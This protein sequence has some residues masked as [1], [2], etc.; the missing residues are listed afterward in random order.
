MQAAT[1]H[2]RIVTHPAALEQ[3]MA[4][5]MQL[6]RAR[7][8]DIVCIVVGYALTW[9]WALDEVTNGIPSWHTSVAGR[10]ETFTAAG[11]WIAVIS[12][13]IFTYSW[14]RWVWKVGV[15]TRFLYHVS[16]LR[17]RLYPAHPDRMGGLG[18]LSDVQT[19]FALLLFG[20]G[21]LFSAATWYKVMIEGTDVS[22]YTVWV[23][24]V[25]Y[26]ILAPGVFLAPLFLFT[27]KLHH[28]KTEGLLRFSAAGAMITRRFERRWMQARRSGEDIL[29]TTGHSAM[30]D[31]RTNFETVQKMRVVPFDARSVLEL[32]G[33]AAGPFVPLAKVFELPEKVRAFF[34]LIS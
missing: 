27:R 19:S 21:I 15:W 5:A 9:G 31:F 18:C 16:R 2:L 25:G 7:A 17:L 34:E 29:Q 24:I 28:V 33:S 30:A 3:L 1:R 32:F 10:N 11:W 12:L 20:T 14:L 13:P 6:G 4:R 26:V 8:A 23:P 22:N